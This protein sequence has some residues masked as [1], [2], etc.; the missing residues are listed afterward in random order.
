MQK[1]LLI[2]TTILFTVFLCGSAIAIP[3]D[4]NQF[5]PSATQYGFD[6][7]TAGDTDISEG[8]L[9]VSDGIV[10]AFSTSLPPDMSLPNTYQQIGSRDMI[11]LDFSSPVSAIGMSIMNDV[12]DVPPRDPLYITLSVFDDND[13]L[14]DQSSDSRRQTSQREADHSGLGR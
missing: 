8:M 2:F 3:I 1:K 7:V 13:Q 5:D 10:R 12:A 14:I 6:D 9:S 4:R 11:R